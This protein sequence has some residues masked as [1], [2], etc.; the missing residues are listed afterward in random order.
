M[1]IASMKLN[2][3]VLFVVLSSL[4]LFAVFFFW[5]S[6]VSN[7]CNYDAEPWRAAQ[8]SKNGDMVPVSVRIVKQGLEHQRNGDG[9]CHNI[10][11]LHRYRVDR[12]ATG[13]WKI[14]MA[15]QD[16]LNLKE[17]DVDGD[18]RTDDDT[19]GCHPFDL[20]EENPLTP[21][22]PFY[23]T[24]VGSQRFYGGLSLAHAD[25]Y[26][27]KVYFTEDGMNA[28]EEG[29]GN[30]PRRNWTLFNENYSVESPYKMHG[31]WLWQKFDFLNG[32]ADY[33]VSF[34]EASE[35]RHLV[36]RYHMGIEGFRWVVRNGAEF[37]ISE[38]VYR[39]AD[40]ESGKVGGKI[41]R[42]NPTK[43]RWAK[44]EPKAPHAIAFDPR[45]ADY[46]KRVFDDVN[47]VGWYMFKDTLVSGYVGLKWYAFE[48]DAVVHRPVR[49]SETVA[50]AEVKT[51]AAPAFY[52]SAC[53]VPYTLWRQVLRL[54]SS[55]AFAGPRGFGF[56]QL[57][58]MGSMSVHN[59]S[60]QYLPHDQ[61]E[62]VTDISL[63]D[64]LAW[65]NALSQQESKTPC[66]YT[67]AGFT[68]VFREVVRSP[69]F[70]EPTEKAV[71]VKWDADGYRLP[72]ASEWL[73][74][75][76]RETGARV[77]SR[78]S[79]KGTRSVGVCKPNAFGVYDMNDNVREWVWPDGD[80]LD[81]NAQSAPCVMGGDFSG[82]P[83][84]ATPQTIPLSENPRTG[85]RVT[86]RKTGQMPPPPFHATAHKMKTGSDKQTSKTAPTE[87]PQHARP[88]CLPVP[89]RSYTLG[90]TEITYAQWRTVYDIAVARGFKFDFSGDMGSMDYWGFGDDWKAAPHTPD[91][92]VTGISQYDAMVWCNALSEASGLKPLYYE[93]DS[94]K[95]PLRR[96]PV[97]RPPQ[98]LLG[99][100]NTLWK[101]GRLV[102]G[103]HAHS[104]V[105]KTVHLLENAAGY[106]LPKESEFVHAAK[107]GI[108]STLDTDALL[109]QAWLADNSDFRT[110]PVASKQPNAWGLHDLYGNVSELS[111]PDKKENKG[112]NQTGGYALRMG[113]SFMDVADK[114]FS[115][116]IM[117][118][119]SGLPYPDIGFRVLLQ[120]EQ[121]AQ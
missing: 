68:E 109:A 20:S 60:G 51:G 37:F 53:E 113:A 43:I 86:R 31:V 10:A 76:G 25:S 74:A 47:A 106:R 65:C 100:L 69:I 119:S 21:V 62:P 56:D 38:E 81:L 48:A 30:Q 36:M 42:C 96:S 121:G 29:A 63:A 6:K 90:K 98:F 101:S 103:A 41:H 22:A 67:D 88:I 35:L 18:G 78:A 16:V 79:S 70:P 117:N 64:A 84:S 54:A 108:N 34:D 28:G 5:K 73:A 7:S 26:D 61:S 19:V 116:L 75:S 33:R 82:H 85:F 118:Q 3:P 23:D 105:W 102:P 59:P 45:K 83:V 89:Q 93:D 91:E 97:F 80:K 95:L 114:L 15:R 12:T 120:Q 46:Q 77:S 52:I 115:G 50:M 39:G 87:L 71:H 72:T 55:S 99:E 111:T 66:Y 107:A 1:L 44:Y 2:R 32:G 13:L 24:T 104:G 14:R 112:K 57:G 8:L 49:P 94:F 4:L 11:A 27:K 9:N 110:R 17:T 92:P 58:A 40:D